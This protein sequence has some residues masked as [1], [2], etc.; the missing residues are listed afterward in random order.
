MVE[1]MVSGVIVSGVLASFILLLSVA[2]I[3]SKNIEINIFKAG[4]R[5][6][7]GRLYLTI[8][9]IMIITIIPI[10]SFSVAYWH[11]GIKNVL[12][13]EIINKDFITCLYFSVVT[14]TNLGYGDFIP[15]KASRLPVGA[16]SLVGY[17]Y[18]GVA[19][20]VIIHV[21]G[22]RPKGWER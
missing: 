13:G 15:T 6:I 7:I 18:L 2:S 4:P 14:F 16:E 8:F 21:L 20:G 19:L 22:I 11:F 3:S 5:F 17:L 10:G 1:N 9:L 12:T